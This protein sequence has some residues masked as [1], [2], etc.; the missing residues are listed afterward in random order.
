[1][2]TRL[3]LDA[4]QTA[5]IADRVR[6]FDR[7]SPETWRWQSEH[8]RRYGALPLYLGWTETLGIQPDGSLVRWS[9]EQEYEGVKPIEVTS[10]CALAVVQA[11][12]RYSVLKDFSPRRPSDVPDCRTCAGAGRVPQLPD[13]ICECV[14]LGWVPRSLEDLPVIATEHD[15]FGASEKHGA[16]PEDA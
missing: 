11:V 13:L 1:M 6:H 14:G 12:Q 15:E 16:G 3:E 9:T 10:E 4:T 7:E 5:F 8:V 2:R